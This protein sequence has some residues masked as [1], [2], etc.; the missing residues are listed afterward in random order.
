MQLQPIQPNNPT[1]GILQ[2]YRKTSYGEYLKGVYKGKKI[3]V[4]DAYKNNQKLIYVSDNRLLRWI[5]SKLIYFQNGIKKVAR[6]EAGE[7]K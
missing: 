5:K 6:S 2:E 3:E 4:F 7:I 1:F